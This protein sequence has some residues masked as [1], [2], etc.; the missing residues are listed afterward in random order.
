MILEGKTYKPLADGVYDAIVMGTGLTE[1]IIAG[2]LATKGKKVLHIDRN[3]YYG[4][5]AASLNLTD[6][7]TQLVDRKP[8]E[9]ELKTLGRVHDYSVDLVPKLLM[10]NG[11]LVKML[12]LT[13]VTRY[14]G[15]KVR[16]AAALSPRPVAVDRRVFGW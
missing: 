12:I 10:G 13:G 11:K 14:L 2:L 4:G 15:F 9:N 5:M 3:G 7:F 8:N 1:C 6:L 16:A